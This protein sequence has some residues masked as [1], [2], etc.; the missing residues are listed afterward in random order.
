MSLGGR[1]HA[2]TR[3]QVR[4][5]AGAGVRVCM[6]T[7]GQR[8]CA[9]G[10]RA[11][12]RASARVQVKRTV[13]ATFTLVNA[14]RV[15]RLKLNR[16]PPRRRS[17][18][19]WP[20]AGTSAARSPGVIALRL[21]TAWCVHG[22]GP[23]GRTRRAR[24][25]GGQE[26][27]RRSRGAG[28][29]ARAHTHAPART[30]ARACAQRLTWQPEALG[31]DERTPRGAT[32][33]ARVRGKQHREQRRKRPQVSAAGPKRRHTC[34]CGVLLQHP[35]FPSPSPCPSPD[36][37]DLPAPTL[38]GSWPPRPSSFQGATRVTSRTENRC[39]GK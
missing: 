5:R 14:V 29:Q 10:G 28:R 21:V 27:A 18:L 2:R 16:A 34:R 38:V 19:R 32:R 1:V 33:C 25:A 7:P 22:A 13:P 12:G 9:H 23:G 6:H 36:P 26:A 8:G 39:F 4:A 20:C 30:R 11:D 35:P 37:A 15:G 17:G 3:E 31:A 24:A